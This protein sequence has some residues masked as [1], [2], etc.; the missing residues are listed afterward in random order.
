MTSSL[1][2]IVS[3]ALAI[4]LLLHH[5]YIHGGTLFQW[6][7]VDN[8]ETWIVGLLGIALGAWASQR[9]R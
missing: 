6:S 1:I 2:V 3:A 7:D 4:A 9:A 5:A 8:H